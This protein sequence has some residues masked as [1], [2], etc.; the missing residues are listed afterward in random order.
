MG[1][2]REDI[3]KGIRGWLECGSISATS[4]HITESKLSRS[5]RE[6]GACPRNSSSI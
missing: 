4:S 6:L 2:E 3:T 5:A 1:E